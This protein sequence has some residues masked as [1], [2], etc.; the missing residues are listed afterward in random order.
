VLTRR[1]GTRAKD[2]LTHEISVGWKLGSGL[3]KCVTKSTRFD[4]ELG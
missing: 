3:Q 2:F 1:T 4:G